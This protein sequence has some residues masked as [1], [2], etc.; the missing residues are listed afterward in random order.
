MKSRDDP[1]FVALAKTVAAHSRSI[2][3]QQQI[4][5]EKNRL[6]DESQ[7]MIE[8]LNLI[9]Q[10]ERN[11]TAGR[12]VDFFRSLRDYLCPADTWRR[13]AF[14]GFRKAAQLVLSDAI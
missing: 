12:A 13:R 9:I 10:T 3:V 6:I 1:S 5:D 14:G 11:S 7:A 8:D 2:A 4:I